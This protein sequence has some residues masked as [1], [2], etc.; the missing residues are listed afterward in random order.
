MSGK[1]N[2]DVNQTNV[3]NANANTAR[4]AVDPR[5]A[6][7]SNSRE[8]TARAICESVNEVA[9]KLGHPTRIVLDGANPEGRGAGI[10][11]LIAGI[12]ISSMLDQA[13]KMMVDMV[14][15][16]GAQ[17]VSI[18]FTMLRSRLGI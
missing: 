6:T 3:G 1:E 2:F 7:Q 15:Q 4:G 17:A 5:N 14:A 10:G 12:P 13:Q 16:H 8:M 9:E 18:A 11:D